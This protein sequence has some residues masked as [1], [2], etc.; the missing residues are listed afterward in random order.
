MP[1]TVIADIRYDQLNG[2]LYLRFVSGDLYK[3]KNVPAEVYEQLM[4]ATSKGTFL[5]KSIKRN[6]DY[7]KIVNDKP[8]SGR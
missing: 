7:Q 6:F 2:D 1:S 3:Y 4:K 8:L 5:N